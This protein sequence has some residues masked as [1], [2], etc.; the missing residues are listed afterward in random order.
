MTA[1]SLVLEEVVRKGGGHVDGY[2][3]FFSH[4]AREKL[5]IQTAVGKQRWKW[6]ELC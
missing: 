6:I 3:V 1:E 2:R 4:L 5:R